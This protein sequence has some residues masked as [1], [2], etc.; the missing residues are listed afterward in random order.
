ML[1]AGLGVLT[2]ALMRT[3]NAAGNLIFSPGGIQNIGSTAGNPTMQITILAA[4]TNSASLQLN[5]FAG[6]LFCNG[7][8]IGY[9]DNFAGVSVP[10]NSQVPIPLQLTLYP[11]GLVSDLINS[12]INKTGQQNFDLEA[13]ANVNG[14]QVDVPLKYTLNV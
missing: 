13:K 10:G 4:N 2:Y 11:V 6:N 14:A 9:V 5:S 8:L 7:T 1:F 12:F 3:A